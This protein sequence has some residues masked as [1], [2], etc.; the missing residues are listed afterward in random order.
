MPMKFVNKTSQKDLVAK[1][2]T[3]MQIILSLECKLDIDGVV[4]ER[5]NSTTNVLEL[6]LSCIN[7]S[8]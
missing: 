8:I 7:P 2:E 6:R 4:Q 5:R 3:L 1:P